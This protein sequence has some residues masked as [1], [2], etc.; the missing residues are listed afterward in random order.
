MNDHAARCHQ[1]AAL[2]AELSLRCSD[3]WV[4]TGSAAAW[5]IGADI[6]VE[7]IDVFASPRDAHTL[8]AQWCEHRMP[9]EPGEGDDLLRSVHCRFAFQPLAVC[10]SGGV[11]AWDGHAWQPVRVRESA[12]LALFGVSLFVP[13]R[14]EQIRL[15]R[16]FGRG[17][18]KLL[19]HALSHHQEFSSC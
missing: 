19:I 4:L 16:Q 11:D 9:A 18:D 3:P 8:M 6:A 1:L 10:V 15:L 5:L 17:N 7:Q 2:A 14:H 13:P 12:S